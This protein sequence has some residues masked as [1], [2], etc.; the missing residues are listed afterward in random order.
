MAHSRH[1]QTTEGVGQGLDRPGDSGAGPSAMGGTAGCRPEAG[2]Q[3][4][5][6]GCCMTTALALLL[7][8]FAVLGLLLG[9]RMLDARHWAASLRAYRL[10]FP[11]NLTIDDVTG[12]LTN[13]AAVTHPPLW[14]LLPMSPISLEVSATSRGI[15]HYLLVVESAKDTML[16]GVRAALPGARIEEAPEYLDGAPNYVVAAEGKLTSH[17]RPMAHDRAEGTSA[18]LLAAM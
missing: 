17:A 16:S 8:G 4:R 13:I 14:S 18:A 1:R 7:A 3:A 11:A 9:A 5:D 10:Y 6:R 15:A 2:G 12:Y